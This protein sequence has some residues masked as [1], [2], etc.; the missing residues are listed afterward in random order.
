MYLV[1][2]S[3]QEGAD[4]FCLQPKRGLHK[5]AGMQACLEVC[6]LPRW[7]FLACQQFPEGSNYAL[8]V[9]IDQ[10]HHEVIRMQDLN[11]EM[12]MEVLGREV[13]QVECQDGIALCRY[14]GHHHMAIFGIDGHQACIFRLVDCNAGIG[15]GSVCGTSNPLNMFGKCLTRR[16]LLQSRQKIAGP[17]VTDTGRP[18]GRIEFMAGQGQQ[19]ITHDHRKHDASIKYRRVAIERNHQRS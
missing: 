14:R 8:F 6:N 9:Q 19:N 13:S 11:L 5:A 10:V 18:L 2:L 4:I 1:P 12:I 7:I 16:A 15:K 17:F 3:L